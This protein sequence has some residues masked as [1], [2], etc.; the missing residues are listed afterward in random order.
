MNEREITAYCYSEKEDV[1]IGFGVSFNIAEESIETIGTDWIDE[2]ISDS[3]WENHYEFE[4]GIEKAKQ[5]M[6]VESNLTF[7]QALYSVFGDFLITFQVNGEEKQL[8]FEFDLNDVMYC[9]LEI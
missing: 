7:R 2:G 1:S 3:F 4:L 5:L 9:M 8:N 6:S